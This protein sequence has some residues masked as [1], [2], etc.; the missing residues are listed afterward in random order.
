MI[1]ILIRELTK[2]KFIKQSH[3]SPIKSWILFIIA[4]FFGTHSNAQNTP[5]DSTR[6]KTPQIA[7]QIGTFGAWV[8]YEFGLSSSIS[9]HTEVGLKAAYINLGNGFQWPNEY[10]SF[11]ED[12]AIV[13]VIN[14]EPRW[15]YNQKKQSFKTPY[16][17]GN[18]IT[19]KIGYSPSFLL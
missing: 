13:P 12:Y 19:L 7:V 14:I 16:N 15:Y 9:L 1:K 10:Y 5:Q 17:T 18:F 11:Q 3:I 8:S 2:V 4:V 6:F